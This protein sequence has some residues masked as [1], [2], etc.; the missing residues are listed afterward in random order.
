MTGEPADRVY[1]IQPFDPQRHD[2]TGFS[3]GVA[4]VD[5]FLRLTAKKQQKDDLV[6]VRVLVARGDDSVL[7]FHAINAHSV[8]AGEIGGRYEKTAPRHG[9][10]PAA[11]IAMIGVH[12]TLRGQSLGK[13]LLVDALQQI[14]RAAS[15]VG[16]AVVVL[17]I[18][19]DGDAEAT[20]RRATYY[21]SFGFIEFPLQPR[22]MFLPL[23]TVRD[24]IAGNAS[25][26]LARLA[27]TQ[28]D[29][30]PVPRRQLGDPNAS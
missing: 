1:D 9:N 24:I 8:Q 10:V 20:A 16:T 30:G 4:Q 22:R 25:R 26:R 28:P 23:A 3:C 19:D 17:D 2:R 15:T 21:R 27:G 11:Y 13:V 29:L 12:A 6:R 7:G 14:S 5:N 18:L